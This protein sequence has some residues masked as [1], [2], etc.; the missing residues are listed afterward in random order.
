MPSSLAAHLAGPDHCGLAFHP[1]CPTC[2]AERLSGTLVRPALIGARSR[3]LL[4]AGVLA[5]SLATPGATA[6]AATE[7]EQALADVV[8][9]LDGISL[10]P[11]EQAALDQ[12]AAVP[13]PP[14]EEPELPEEADV[15]E[16]PA[17]PVQAPAPAPVATP[18]PA[19]AAPAPVQKVVE[20]RPA[21]TTPKPK[22]R[23]AVQPKPAVPSAP[24]PAAVSVEAGSATHLVRAG[25]SLWTIAA[26]RLDPNASKAEIARELARIWALNAEAIETGDPD[27]I[28]PGQTLRLPAS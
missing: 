19:P 21:K 16:E 20:K 13:D 27:L 4:A 24:A 10:T 15:P 22:P 9:Q 1:R 2:R 14:A 25:E 17:A 7:E 5:G 11:E 12:E 26:A 6:L 28:R 3:A 18:A 23:R 8:G